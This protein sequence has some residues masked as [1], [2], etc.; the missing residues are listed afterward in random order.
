MRHVEIDLAEPFE[1]VLATALSLPA[2]CGDGASDRLANEGELEQVIRVLYE[3]ANGRH[4]ETEVGFVPIAPPVFDF[5][6]AKPFRVRT[7]TDLLIEAAARLIAG[8]VTAD[9]RDRIAED[10]VDD[11]SSGEALI[12]YRPTHRSRISLVLNAK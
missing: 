9:V 6:K 10:V 3:A 2:G 7:Q 1:R 11:K 12:H 4:V 5:L 8:S